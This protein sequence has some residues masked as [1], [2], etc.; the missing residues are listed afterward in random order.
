MPF[1]LAFPDLSPTTHS[2]S[3][4]T[5]LVL[6]FLLFLMII[7]DGPSHLPPCSFC[8]SPNTIKARS[9]VTLSLTN[10]SMVL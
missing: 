3:L 10:R 9:Q 7:R 5:F 8:V 4:C 6:F 2:T 1:P